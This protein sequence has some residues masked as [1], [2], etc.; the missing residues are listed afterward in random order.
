MIEQEGVTYHRIMPVNL[1]EEHAYLFAREK[2]RTIPTLRLYPI[3]N[4]LINEDQYI[5]QG[6]RLRPEALLSRENRETP[7][8]FTNLKTYS[9]S[10]FTKRIRVIKSALWLI[11]GWSTQYFHWF[12]DVLHKQTMALQMDVNLPMIVP[13][14]FMRSHF[15]AESLRVL[16]PPYIELKRSEFAVVRKLMTWSDEMWSGNYIEPAIQ[17]LRSRFLAAIGTDDTSSRP[18]RMIYIS[19]AGAKH[20]RITNEDE[21]TDRLRQ[22]GFEVL[23]AEKLSLHEQIRM[24]SEC[25][26]VVAAHGAGL[27]N[28][29]FMLSGMAVLEIRHPE[30][31]VQNCYF[32]LASAL[33]I[34]YYYMVGLPQ[35]DPMPSVAPDARAH[36]QD[37]SVDVK[38]LV[39]LILSIE[40]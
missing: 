21:V 31:T 1:A 26:L 39:N 20:R 36:L 22:I 12:A 8:V 2:V 30:S 35:G 18:W 27:T 19:R 5:W 32:S 29:L 11:D 24:F 13:E 14:S 17:N 25:R 6:L 9:R 23:H 37:L 34:N 3:R 7:S 38:E 15:V 10:L 40:G 28:T 33:G 16:Q 4:A